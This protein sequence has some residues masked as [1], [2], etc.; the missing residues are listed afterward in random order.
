[1]LRVAIVFFGVPNSRR[2]YVLRSIAARQWPWPE[3]RHL[4]DV[5]VLEDDKLGMA[6]AANFKLQI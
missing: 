6:Q 1:M 5:G 4:R 2:R 3:Y